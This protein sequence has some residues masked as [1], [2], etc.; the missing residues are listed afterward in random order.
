MS[1]PRSNTTAV[2]A[3]LLRSDLRYF[4]W[5]CFGT[6][7]PGTPYLPNWHIDAIV[8]QLMLVKDGITARLLINQPPRSG[9]SICVSVAYTAWLLGRD[10]TLRI[11]VASYS[12]ELADELHRQ[13]RM[14]ID[15]PWYRALFPKMRPAKDTD[16]ELVTTEGGSRYATSVGGTLTGRGADLIVVDEP[17]KAEEVWSQASRKRVIVWFGDSLVPRLNDKENGPIIVV[18]QRLH[19]DDVAGHLLRQGSW[20]H[21]DLP[22]IAVE[23][24]DI[25]VGHDKVVRRRCGDVLH[26]ERESKET[27]DRMKAEIGSLTFSAQYQQRP[28][29]LEGNL[30]K[31]EWL[32]AYDLPPELGPGDLIVQSWDVAMMT[33]A[34]NDFSACTTWLMAGSDYYLLDVFRGRLQYPDLRRK[35]AMLAD[36]YRAETI[37][38]ENAGPGMALLQDLRRDLLPG[39]P[40]PIG[41]KPEGS[42]ADRMVAQSAK[43][44]AGHVYLPK[45][46]EWLE[47]F[48]LEL[49]AFPQGRH[50]DQMDSV[51]QFLKWAAKRQFFDTQYC[52]I[53]LPFTGNDLGTDRSRLAGNEGANAA[54][55]IIGIY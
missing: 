14:V 21:L 32:G 30:I 20:S 24:S 3:A 10:P 13:F 55:Q 37:L 42:K 4:V 43:I 54:D 44:E 25:P 48:L 7:F 2:L 38:I 51:S 16:N 8:H 39:M 23:D 6:I 26:P 50:D 15:A 46:A 18:M 34:S 41:Q 49:L 35:I 29:P 12:S 9:K 17:Q 5:K 28:V 33:G 47:V 27:L 45:Q 22:A 52:G 40:F 31:R 36:R 19:E 53:G 1:R 11:I